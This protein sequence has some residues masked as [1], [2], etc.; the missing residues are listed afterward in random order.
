M[1]GKGCKSSRAHTPITSEAQQGMM[2]AELRRRK[3]GKKERMKG[4][5]TEELRSHLH[6]SKGKDLTARAGKGDHSTAK[7]L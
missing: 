2:G 7:P 6:E 5:T 1:P 4:I 3:E